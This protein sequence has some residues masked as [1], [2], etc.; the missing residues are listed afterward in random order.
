MCSDMRDTL[1][2][3]I[4]SELKKSS[5]LIDPEHI[6]R[7]INELCELEARRSG[8][9]PPETTEAQINAVITRITARARRKK[10]ARRFRP[11]ISLAAAA[12]CVVLVLGF[13][14]FNYVYTHVNRRF[15]PKEMGATLC[16]GTDHCECLIK[17]E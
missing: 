12:A 10:P 1:W 2:R 9:R 16:Y 8:L 4:E 15:F 17:K 7:R 5:V 6:D 3:D 11:L 14:S 13:F